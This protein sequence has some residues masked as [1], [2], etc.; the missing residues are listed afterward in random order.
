MELTGARV[1]AETSPQLEHVLDV[2]LCQFCHRRKLRQ[3]SQIIRADRL[4]GGLLKHDL[5]E[6]H[7]I[8]VGV[9]AWQRPPRQNAA[10]AIEPG[11]EGGW[12]GGTV[13]RGSAILPWSAAF[14]SP[15]LLGHG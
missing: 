3:E 5:R 1:V 6:P 14:T 9:L 7:A 8:G 10:M 13:L 12:V 4:D 2:G 11:E 15:R